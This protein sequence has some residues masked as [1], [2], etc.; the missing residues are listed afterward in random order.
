MKIKTIRGE[1]Q[2]KTRLDLIKRALELKIPGCRQKKKQE[3]IE[4]IAITSAPGHFPDL[5]DKTR[6]VLLPV[7]LYL[8]HVYWD[9]A[10]RDLKRVKDRIGKAAQRAHATLRVYDITY[11][12][13]D[14]TNA[15]SSF[16]VDIDLQAGNWYVHLWSPWRSYCVDL[17]FRTG[18]GRFLPIARS[19]VVETPPAYPSEKEAERY[20][21]VLEDYKRVEI[22]PT[23]PAAERQYGLSPGT[24]KHTEGISPLQ[25]QLHPSPIKE[26]SSYK[27][28]DESFQM[29]MEKALQGKLAEL[30]RFRLAVSPRPSSKAGQ[31][32]HSISKADLTEMNE[33]GLTAGISSE[34][35]IPEK[36]RIGA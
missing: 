21:L 25:F 26:E 32:V 28:H 19:N 2:A 34:V 27:E 9:I 36:R 4:E 6:V 23:V 15:H 18:D 35:I 12:F 33:R 24:K 8:I 31:A 7:D 1:P 30:Y 22:V 5:Y 16:D 20:M 29:D 10:K 13:F 11:I 17:G 14:G 3:L